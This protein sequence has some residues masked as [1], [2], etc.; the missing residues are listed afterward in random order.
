MFRFLQYVNSKRGL[1]L[2][3]YPALYRWSINDVAAFWEDT[4]H[5]VGIRA[6]R[7]FHEVGR[8]RCLSPLTTS[9]PVPEACPRPRR[10]AQ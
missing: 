1:G 7:P 10:L 2:A 8:Q 9:V 6:S 5:F 3:G 4:W